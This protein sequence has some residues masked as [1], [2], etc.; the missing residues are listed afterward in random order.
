MALVVDEPIINKPFVEPDRH[1]DYIDNEPQLIESRRRAGYWQRPRTRVVMGA[2]AEEQ[3]IP[4]E[5]VNEIRRRVGK[6][7][8]DGYP[9]ATG[10]TRQLLRYWN[11]EDRFRPLFFCQ[12]E[13]V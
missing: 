3:F 4:L 2:V 6:W 11:R 7:R 1:Y 5:A 10:I 13:A 12:R 8:A 9:G